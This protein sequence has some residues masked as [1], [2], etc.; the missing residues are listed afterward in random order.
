MSPG[1]GPCTCFRLRRTARRVSQHYDHALAAAGLSVNQYSILRRSEA[2]ART[3]GD[4]AETLGMDRTT[5]TRNL[6]PLLEAGWLVE[7]RGTDG[8]QRLIALTAAGRQ[9]IDLAMPLWRQAQ[10]TLQSRLGEHA[11]LRLHDDL[12]TLHAAMGAH[13]PSTP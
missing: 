7:S 3:V 9:R 10:A 5:L 1:S 13:A 11:V 6:R 12:D 4:L 2:A 8:R